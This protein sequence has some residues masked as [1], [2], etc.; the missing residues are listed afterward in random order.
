QGRSDA[1]AIPY[2]ALL[3]GNGDQG[4]VFIV[5]NGKAHKMPVVVRGITGT[6]VLVN[7]LDS[8]KAL[9]VKGGPYLTESTAVV[10]R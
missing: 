1:V 10:V 9:I 4:V 2:E 8:T 6:H 3:D 7:G 5:E